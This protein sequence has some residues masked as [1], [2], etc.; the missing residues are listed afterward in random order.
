MKTTM[1]TLRREMVSGF[2]SPSQLPD[3]YDRSEAGYS[4]DKKYEIFKHID[5]PKENTPVNEEVVQAQI[6][7]G[8]LLVV[9]RCSCL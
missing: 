3:L 7:P 5:D 8:W 4:S 9:G 6:K 1:V 2:K